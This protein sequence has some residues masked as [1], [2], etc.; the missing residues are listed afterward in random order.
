MKISILRLKLNICQYP[1]QSGVKRFGVRYFLVFRKMWFI[2]LNDRCNKE[3]T[4]IIF[5]EYR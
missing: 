4:R 2:K 1:L 5:L 3:V